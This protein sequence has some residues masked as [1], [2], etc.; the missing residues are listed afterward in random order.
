MWVPLLLVLC[1]FVGLTIG[2][3]ILRVKS[4]EELSQIRRE[5]E[6]GGEGHEAV[7]RDLCLLPDYEAG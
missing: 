1:A 7:P 6:A 3:P 2:E 4:E 5:E